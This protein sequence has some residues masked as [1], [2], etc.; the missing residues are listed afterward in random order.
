MNDE[1]N[2][3]SQNALYPTR[4]SLE[5]HSSLYAALCR[6]RA[7]D[8]T[9]VSNKTEKQEHTYLVKEVELYEPIDIES[10]RPF[11]IIIN[12]FFVPGTISV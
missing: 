2:K 9:R 11:E 8:K 12:G 6:D 5:T 4:L 7:I 10:K 3:P 1:M